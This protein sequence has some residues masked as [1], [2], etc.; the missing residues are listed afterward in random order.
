ML[1]SASGDGV[2]PVVE[3]FP[4]PRP[5]RPSCHRSGEAFAAKAPP[6]QRWGGGEIRYLYPSL[7]NDALIPVIPA[8]WAVQRLYGSDF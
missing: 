5:S 8:V 7:E 2:V 6:D 1:H 3:R 4:L